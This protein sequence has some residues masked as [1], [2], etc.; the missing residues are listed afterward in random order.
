MERIS[1]QVLTAEFGGRLR[2]REVSAEWQ[3]QDPSPFDG[4]TLFLFLTKDLK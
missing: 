3:S 2:L 4:Q 1:S